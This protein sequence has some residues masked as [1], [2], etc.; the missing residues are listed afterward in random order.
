MINVSII[1]PIY[2]VEPYI[3]PCINSVLRQTY[4]NL[5]VILG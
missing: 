1:I 5:E 3:E 4:R 2:K